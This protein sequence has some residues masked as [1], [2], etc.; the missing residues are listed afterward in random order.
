LTHAYNNTVEEN[1]VEYSNVVGEGIDL[2]NSKG[3]IIQRNVL[4][5]S[6]YGI[7]LT[8]ADQNVLKENTIARC[9]TAVSMGLSNGN[10][11]YNN[12]LVNNTLDVENSYS[13]NNWSRSYPA[14][15]NYWSSHN[16]TDFFEDVYQNET[17]SD[18]IADGAYKI[19]SSNEDAYPLAAMT[20]TFD[21]GVWNSTPYSVDVVSNSTISGFSFNPTQGAFLSFNIT[22]I[23]NTSGF[24]RASIPRALLWADDGWIITLDGRPANYTMLVDGENTYLYVFYGDDV[25]E[26]VIE[27]TGVIPEGSLV[28][29]SMLAMISSM[30]FVVKTRLRRKPNNPY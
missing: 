9:S 14:G 21:A 1:L 22:G 18:A 7:F 6:Y 5:Y 26:V 12:N 25:K 15:G 24:C 27:G 11:I 28:A 20:R 17:G 4:T 3:N 19:D 23:N 8:L 2:S 13:T 10:V 30:S 29:I 16:N